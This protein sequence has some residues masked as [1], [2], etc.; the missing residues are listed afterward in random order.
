[1]RVDADEGAA[2]GEKAAAD[3]K[4]A[5][6]ENSAAD[7]VVVLLLPRPGLRMH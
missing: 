7:A 5:A 1:V 6:D 4:T 3:E 2:T